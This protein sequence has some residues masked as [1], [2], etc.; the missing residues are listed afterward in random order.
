MNEIEKVCKAAKDNCAY[1]GAMSA[2]DKNAMLKLAANS[3]I[4]DSS[5]IIKANALDMAANSA[6]PQHILD[7][8]LLTEARIRD[9]AEGLIQLTLLPDPIGEV[10]EQWTTETN[11]HIK[12]VRV[13]LGVLGIIYEAR[14][15]VTIDALG[16]CLKS[17]N[18]VVLRGSKDAINSNIALVNCVKNTLTSSGYNAEFIQLI[19]DTTHE[20][21]EIFMK[22]RAYVDVLIPRGSASLINTT[23]EK[24]TI[25]VIETGVGNCH[26][27]VEKSGDFVM[28]QNIILNG[29][30]QR[31]SVCNALESLLIDEEIANEFL[32]MIVKSLIEKGVELV[33]CDKSVKICSS[34]KSATDEDFY[35][36]FLALK[37]S[38][39][40]VSGVDEAIS[41]INRYSSA[42]SDVIITT[43]T[44]AAE[45]FLNGVDSAAVYFNASTR[46][47]DGFQFGFG[48]EMGIST[49]K[50]H[51]RGPLG[52]KQLTSE[53]YQITGSGQTR[54]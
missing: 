43:N 8:L 18:A 29:K 15:N 28:A 27:Y 46:F 9:M 2:V 24:S 34:V 37:I 19:T 33:G 17:G 51:A 36:E 3:I 21:A 12:K 52:L 11:L 6:K 53:K 26:A 39:K 23:V 38:L 7:R 48:A 30:L 45:K 42:H 41:H 49:Q 13:P 47:T 35:T 16:L 20:G 14:P 10:M 40:I 54:K 31:P 1:I 32:P 44:S 5:E 4:A 25:P 22:C 50:L